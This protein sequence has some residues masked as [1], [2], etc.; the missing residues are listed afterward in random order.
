MPCA[1]VGYASSGLF[2]RIN[3]SSLLPI[4]GRRAAV[5]TSFDALGCFGAILAS[6]LQTLAV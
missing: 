2:L 1:V 4:R 5:R 6:V 3:A